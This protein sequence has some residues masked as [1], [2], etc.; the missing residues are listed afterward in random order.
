MGIVYMLATKNDHYIGSTIHKLNQRISQHKYD[1]NSWLNEK[2]HYC[3]SFEIIK[4]DNYEVNKDKK[5]Q[6]DKEYYENNK[7]EIRKQ[8]KEYYEKNK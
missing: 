7:E 2:K 6:Y 3:N 5:K 8:Q 1:Y 4:N